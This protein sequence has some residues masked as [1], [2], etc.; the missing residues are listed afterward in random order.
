MLLK[1]KF[2]ILVL[3]LE[4]TIIFIITIK[5]PQAQANQ[6]IQVALELNLKEVEVAHCLIEQYLIIEA[7]QEALTIFKV[8]MGYQELFKYLLMEVAKEY[9]PKHSI[10]VVMVL[11]I[12]NLQKYLKMVVKEWS[13]INFKKYSI[14]VAKV[15]QITPFKYFPEQ[16]FNQQQ[17]AQIIFKVMAY[18]QF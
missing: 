9:Q 12:T 15:Y 14:K 7:M 10:M 6:A 5:E 17:Q 4:L 2:L 1:L 8:V 16:Y 18:L 3:A 13:I 11:Q